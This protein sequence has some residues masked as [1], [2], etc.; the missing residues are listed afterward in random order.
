MGPYNR[1]QNV[2][3]L[4]VCI[5][6]RSDKYVGASPCTAM[7]VNTKS[8]NFD[9]LW[10]SQP[11]KKTQQMH[12]ALSPQQCYHWKSECK[13]ETEFEKFNGDNNKRNRTGGS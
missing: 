10:F 7:Y 13:R 9:S 6:T 12:E 4:W 8:L 11:V 5:D 2:I 1:E 3:L